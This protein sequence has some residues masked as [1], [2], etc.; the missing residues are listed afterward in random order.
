MPIDPIE[1]DEESS[2]L[3]AESDDGDLATSD[4]LSVQ[5]RPMLVNTERVVSTVS[6]HVSSSG[7]RK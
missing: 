7:W 6:G 3:E 2:E 4:S 1:G 5:D